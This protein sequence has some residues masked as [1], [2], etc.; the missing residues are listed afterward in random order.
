M[1]LNNL[2]RPERHGTSTTSSGSVDLENG[3]GRLE[4]GEQLEEDA[5]LDYADTQKKGEA[6]IPTVCLKLWGLVR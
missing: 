1:A 3:L 2:Q 6:G 4:D 5:E